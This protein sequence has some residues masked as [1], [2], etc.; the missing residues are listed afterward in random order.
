MPL[1]PQP[2]A[3]LASSLEHFSEFSRRYFCTSNMSAMSEEGGGASSGTQPLIITV[4]V[5]IPL[6]EIQVV[7]IFLSSEKDSVTPGQ[8]TKSPLS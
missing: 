4:T 3:N 7:E 5:N 2:G 6:P 1:V 8:T